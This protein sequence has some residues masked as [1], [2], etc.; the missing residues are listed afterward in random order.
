MSLRCLCMILRD[1]SPMVVSEFVVDFDFGFDSM[2][3]QLEEEELVEVSEVVAVVEVEVVLHTVF[4]C[5]SY[6]QAIS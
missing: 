1:Y 6:K 4:V 5:N 3:L 2:L